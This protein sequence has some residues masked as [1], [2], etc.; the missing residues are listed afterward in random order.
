MTFRITK[1]RR[2]RS[3]L[4]RT[5]WRDWQVSWGREESNGWGHVFSD[6]G[7]RPLRFLEVYTPLFYPVGVLRW[8]WRYSPR[9]RCTERSLVMTTTI[10]EIGTIS[11]GT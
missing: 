3:L 1:P 9:D 5:A 8:R 11:H 10:P 6:W 7:G 2:L 4:R